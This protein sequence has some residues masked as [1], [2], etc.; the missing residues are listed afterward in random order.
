MDPMFPRCCGLDVHKKT[1]V[2]CLLTPGTGG[3]SRREKR[4]RMIV[5]SMYV[6]DH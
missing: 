2:A 4:V 1:V 3:R 6:K 5:D